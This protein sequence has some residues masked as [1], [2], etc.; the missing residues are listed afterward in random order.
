MTAIWLPLTLLCALALAT[1]DALTKKALP[2]RDEY[3]VLWLRL[4][5]ALPFLLIPLAF[6]PIPDLGPD[7]L[8]TVLLAL[9]LEALAAICYI[10]A[11]KLSP[12]SLT[13]PFLALTPVFLLVVP[14]LVLGERISAG[15]AI[16]ILLVAI[17]AYLLHFDKAR[18]NWLEPF[19][20]IGRERG[21][22]YMIL[23]A[24]IYSVT[25]TLG[26]KAIG[27][28]SPLFF[29]AC[30]FPA[31]TLILTPPALRG[32]I[33]SGPKPAATRL[34]RAMLLP[35]CCYGVMVLTHMTAISIAPVAYMISVKRL[36]LLIGIYYGH[37]LFG[38]PGIRERALG[39]AVMIAGVTLIAWAP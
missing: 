20:A 12:L 34:L 26:K 2:G 13:L 24:L 21:S 1:S 37:R 5:L 25:S 15:G 19:R 14:F 32:G 28:S 36:S 22:L 18:C 38:E 3:L 33:I 11:L 16:G 29:A 27:A 4:L 39:T 8:P 30:Y 6:I 31:L 9:P 35:A 10:R 23:V 17:G 7:F